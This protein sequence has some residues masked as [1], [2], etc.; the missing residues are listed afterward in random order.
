MHQTHFGQTLT[1]ITL[2]CPIW[3]QYRKW[4]WEYDDTVWPLT[5]EVRHSSARKGL[6]KVQYMK[7][8][9]EAT[10]ATTRSIL[11]SLYIHFSLDHLKNIFR[12]TTKNLAL[13]WTINNPF[14]AITRLSFLPW[15]YYSYPEV[16]YA[17]VLYQPGFVTHP[18][19]GVSKS[20]DQSCQVECLAAALIRLPEMA[21]GTL[22]L[23]KLMKN[24]SIHHLELLE[25]V[26][27]WCYLPRTGVERVL[28]HSSW[29]FARRE[30]DLCHGP[31]W[32]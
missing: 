1:Q 7:A 13:Q 2:G 19:Q 17:S 16:C 6:G 11:N 27:F 12:S 9:T 30:G 29:L 22:H 10:L 31:P 25:S 5:L 23:S 32:K 3:Y 4:C 20:H 24:L 15:T 28:V 21:P 18:L 26:K 14:R 8:W